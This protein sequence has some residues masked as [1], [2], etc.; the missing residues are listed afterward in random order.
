MSRS[1]ALPLLADVR[2]TL[3]YQTEHAKNEFAVQLKKAMDQQGVSP[4]ELATRLGVSRPMV[5][6][7]LGGETNVTIETMVKVAHHL[8]SRLHLGVVNAH[9]NV[10]VAEVIS[11]RPAHSPKVERTYSGETFMRAGG[12][13]DAAVYAAVGS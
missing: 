12:A 7:L 2:N 5:S 9:S 6:K 4:S 8:G 13:Q 3:M 1:E 11:G 10:W